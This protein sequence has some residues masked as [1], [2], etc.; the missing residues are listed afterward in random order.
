[1]HIQLNDTYTQNTHTHTQARTRER[2]STTTYH[3]RA[4]YR[5]QF[6]LMK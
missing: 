2:Q 1:M 4:M 3:E 5:Q 6:G